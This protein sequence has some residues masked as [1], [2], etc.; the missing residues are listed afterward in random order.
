[1][2]GLSAARSAFCHGRHER[3]ITLP[4][5]VMLPA[6]ASWPIP[7][8]RPN[9]FL[10]EPGVS[11]DAAGGVPFDAD[12]ALV[13]VE[14]DAGPDFGV[15]TP[16]E[17]D[18]DEAA[19][20]V[21]LVLAGSVGRSEC[22]EGCGVEAFGHSIRVEQM[23]YF[24]STVAGSGRVRQGLQCRDSGRTGSGTGRVRGQSSR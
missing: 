2:F 24:R 22:V 13:A 18:Q 10:G 19:S 9:I 23:F 21:Q 17:P 20:F 11:G 15:G 6:G 14:G 7:Q 3:S 4:V 12:P 5:L 16:D 1:M 8:P